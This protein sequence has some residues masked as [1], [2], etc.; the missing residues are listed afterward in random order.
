MKSHQLVVILLI[1]AAAVCAGCLEGPDTNIA[2]AP[3]PETAPVVEER[4]VSPVGVA[5]CCG[6]EEMFPA[7][8]SIDGNLSTAWGHA[9]GEAHWIIYDLGST[10]EIDKVRIYADRDRCYSPCK[11]HIYVTD[12]ESMLSESVD[13]VDWGQSNAIKDLEPLLKWHEIELTNATGRYIL[14]FPYTHFKYTGTCGWYFVLE[15]F[16]EFEYLPVSEDG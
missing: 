9:K 2:P 11:I 14:V 12:N 3:T 8:A 4:W 13:D 1:L 10:K 6:E 16:Y 15:E 7:S 5:T